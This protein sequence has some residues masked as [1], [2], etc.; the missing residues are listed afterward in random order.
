[1][2]KRVATRET[3][4]AAKIDALTRCRTFP[5]G[6]HSGRDQGSNSGTCSVQ[7]G[8]WLARG[9]CRVM[10]GVDHEPVLTDGGAARPREGN[11]G[12]GRLFRSA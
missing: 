10:A 7:P 12:L 9:I 2:A 4:N 6:C 5:R 3:R 8:E 11:F 1:M